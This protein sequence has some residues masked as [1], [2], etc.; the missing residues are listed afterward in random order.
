MEALQRVVESINGVLWGIPMMV[1][2]VGFGVLATL[3]LGF[4]QITKIGIGFKEAFSGMFT[5]EK[6]EEGSM[7]SFQSLA[8]AVAAQ[9]GTGNIG[10]VATALASGGP[11]AIFWMWITAIVEYP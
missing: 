2:L 7:S 11:G 5:K 6:T 8:T 9:V 3:Y 4:P 10:G 1:I